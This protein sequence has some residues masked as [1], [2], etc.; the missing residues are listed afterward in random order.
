MK[1]GY[2][3]FPIV[4]VVFDEGDRLEVRNFVGTLQLFHTNHIFTGR[5]DVFNIPMEPGCK[6]YKVDSKKDDI[7]IHGDTIE[8]VSMSCKYF[9]NF[10]FKCTN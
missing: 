9:H 7:W 1:A 2:Q 8:G 4:S 6:A 3:H 5:K 10:L